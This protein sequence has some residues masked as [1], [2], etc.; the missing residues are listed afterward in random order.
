M[1][2]NVDDET[3][4]FKYRVKTVEAAEAPES[5]PQE[6]WHSYVIV[7]GKSVIEGMKPGSYSEVM[8]HAEIV[9]EG[10]NER[11]RSGGSSYASSKKKK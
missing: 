4:E 2:S 8:Q 5:M 9:A 3:N 7:R 11:F 10:L 6:E 1:T